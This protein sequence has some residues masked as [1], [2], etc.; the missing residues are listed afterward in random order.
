MLFALLL[1]SNLLLGRAH[2]VQKDWQHIWLPSCLSSDPLPQAGISRNRQDKQDRPGFKVKMANDVTETYLCWQTLQ[3]CRMAFTAFLSTSWYT[4]PDPSNFG[5]LLINSTA[6]LSL[7]LI[8]TIT[9]RILPRRRSSRVKAKV[10]AIHPMARGVEP[11]GSRPLLPV[12][13][14]TGCAHYWVSQNPSLSDPLT[15]NLF[16]AIVTQ[17][18]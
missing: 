10:L 7:L 18:R 3:G 11:R 15:R 1:K 14:Y 16:C 8:T 2:V 17:S 6:S 5:K 13:Y 9:N 12:Y 4:S